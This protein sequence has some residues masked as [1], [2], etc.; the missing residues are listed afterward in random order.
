M[1]SATG[2][3]DPTMHW[4]VEGYLPLWTKA[5]EPGLGGSKGKAG[6]LQQW[7]RANTRWTNSCWVTGK[8]MRSD[9]LFL[10]AGFFIWN[11]L[12]RRGGRVQGSFSVFCFWI[13]SLKSVSQR[14][15]LGWLNLAPVS[16]SPWLVAEP[17]QFG[18]PAS[19]GFPAVPAQILSLHRDP[20]HVRF[21]ARPI[22]V[23]VLIL[24]TSTKTPLPNK[25]ILTSSR[26]TWF[27]GDYS[28]HSPQKPGSVFSSL[29]CGS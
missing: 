1:R 27:W 2:I 3:G 28:V 5:R 7:G 29:K 17:L 10:S 8:Q 9:A 18:P 16:S 14:H 20:S 11:P 12:G 15:I 24:F 23:C 25:V 19:R 13:T 26:L 21:R 22:P 4:L 6:D